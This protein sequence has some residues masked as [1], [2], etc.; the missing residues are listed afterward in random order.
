MNLTRDSLAFYLM[1][2][3]AAAS[4]LATMPPP[5]QWSYAQWMQ[6][7]ASAALYLIGKLQ[8]SPLKGEHD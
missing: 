1:A 2:L 6:M 5:T 4:L 7:V 8:T 3:A